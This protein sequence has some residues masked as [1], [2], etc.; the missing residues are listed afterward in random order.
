MRAFIVRPFGTQSGVDFEA[1]ERLLIA[2]ALQQLEIEG[3]TTQEMTAQGNI[4]ADMFR[5]LVGADLVV[6]DLSIHN[7]NVFYELG[8]RHGLRGTGTFLLRAKL[9]T[10]PFDLSTDRY[11]VYDP[12]QPG[13]RLDDLVKALRSTLDLRYVDSPVYELLP[14]LRPP[15]PA[16]LQAVPREFRDDVE[17]ARAGGYR[18]DLR[19][20]A[21]EARG[22]EWER[23]GLRVVGRAQLTLRAFAGARETFEWLLKTS[24]NDVEAHQRL[25]TIYQRLASDGS[26][27]PDARRSLL[28]RS[29]QAIRRVLESSESSPHDL[30]EGYALLGRNTKSDWRDDWAGK[31]EA[32]RPA[33]ALRSP[34]LKQAADLY[35]RGYEEDPAHCYSG[36][37]ALGLYRLL[38]ELAHTHPTVW[39][40]GFESETEAALA[41]KTCDETAAQLAGAVRVSLRSCRRRLERQEPR[42]EEAEAW[43]GITEADCAFL[44]GVKPG[45]I[46]QA[47]R[48]VLAGAPDF[49][50][51]S[52]REQLELF[53]AL[54]VRAEL[55]AA[56]LAVFDEWKPTAATGGAG[57]PARVLLFTGHMVDRDGR[58]TPRFPRSAEA[59]RQAKA[60]IA[61]A[62]ADEAAHTTGPVVGIAGGACGG[63][64]LF[65]EVCSEANIPTGLYLAVPPDQFSATSVARGGPTW[66]ERFTALTRRVSP[67]ILGDATTL[68]RWLSSRTGGYSVWN[69]NN[70]WM[71]YNALALNAPFVTLIAL[72]DGSG[73]DGP[74]GTADLVAQARARGH[75]VVVL[76]AGTL[77]SL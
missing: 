16:S 65:H 55:V 46:A 34:L 42:D 45:P 75:K 41:L 30:A 23:E 50:R 33:A 39:V 12:A 36:I 29:T 7:A 5:M 2:P 51:N 54:G 52:A 61:Q 26:L 57:T 40:D 73:G 32:E 1:V 25:A 64:M 74:G 3:R 63:D 35:L 56:A 68:P 28:A 70:L 72:W 60:L 24:E 4:R 38:T 58:A 37:S 47:Y 14:S 17:R 66:V 49:S 19:L 31:A 43:L 9:D 10:F 20:L 48:R 13:A 6:A 71:L 8:I 27:T 77:K 21:H 76:D 44:S 15:D 11:F 62:V 59:E 69:R 67:R 53:A 22:F 18:G